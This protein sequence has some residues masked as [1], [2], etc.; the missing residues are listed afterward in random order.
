MNRLQQLARDVLDY[1]KSRGAGAAAATVTGIA[2][3]LG[4]DSER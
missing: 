2:A 3:G 1:A 4:D